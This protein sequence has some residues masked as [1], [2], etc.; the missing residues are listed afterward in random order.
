MPQFTQSSWTP[1][2]YTHR[3]PD[4]EFS[5]EVPRHLVRLVHPIWSVIAR[6]PLLISMPLAT[7]DLCPCR[8]QLACRQQSDVSVLC[9][10]THVTLV[11]CVSAA[12]GFLSSTLCFSD[13]VPPSLLSLRDRCLNPSLP[14]AV[15][16]CFAW[17]MLRI[18]SVETRS[19]FLVYT[20][21]PLR[22]LLRMLWPPRL[23]INDDG[24]PQLPAH[25]ALV[26]RNFV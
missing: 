2:L 3:C 17:L 16:R 15:P 22:S 5:A 20:P 24:V 12:E 11:S 1:T 26:S 8:G 18:W 9:N 7:H 10:T 13:L 25:V 21:S 6:F 14:V 4:P 23:Q 19:S